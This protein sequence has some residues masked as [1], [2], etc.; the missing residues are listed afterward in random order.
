VGK[1]KKSEDVGRLKSQKPKIIAFRWRG[2]SSITQP[3]TV[4]EEN[5]GL[6]K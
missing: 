1:K 4:D 3:L 5:L 2:D 6:R